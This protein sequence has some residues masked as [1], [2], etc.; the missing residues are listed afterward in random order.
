[1][2]A[3]ETDTSVFDDDTVTHL[4][5]SDECGVIINITINLAEY[6]YS[7]VTARADMVSAI[8]RTFA[9]PPKE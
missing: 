1:M 4:L 8:L 2:R 3:T 6:R 7:T 9:W 5:Y